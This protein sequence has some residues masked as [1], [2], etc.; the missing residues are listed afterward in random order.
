M[1]NWVAP[2][3]QRGGSNSPKGQ[4]HWSKSNG[5]NSSK[6]PHN[7]SKNVTAIFQRVVPK[8]LEGGNKGPMPNGTSLRD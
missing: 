8:V 5:T 6:G 4:H 7:L 1:S 2:M 3:V